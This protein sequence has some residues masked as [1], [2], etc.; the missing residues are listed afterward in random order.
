MLDL[1]LYVAR[2]IM[3]LHGGELWAEQR[4]PGEGVVAL[5]SLP[6]DFPPRSHAV[7]AHGAACY[8]TRL[9]HDRFE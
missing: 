4:G 7:L 1:E 9:V 8:P 2:E 5:I 3:R 6:L